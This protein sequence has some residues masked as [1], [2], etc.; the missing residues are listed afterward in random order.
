MDPHWPTWGKI[1][2]V[3]ANLA[4]FS[5]MMWAL[6]HWIVYPFAEW[7][8]QWYVDATSDWTYAA[9]ITGLGAMPVVLGT[10]A[11]LAYRRDHRKGVIQ[12]PTFWRYIRTGR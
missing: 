3:V 12:S 1:L 11:Y 2:Y 5:A 10:L 6:G 4:L 7:F 9:Q 8:G